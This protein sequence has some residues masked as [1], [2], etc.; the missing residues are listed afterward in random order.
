MTREPGNSTGQPPLEGAGESEGS[1]PGNSIGQPPLEGEGEGEEGDGGGKVGEQIDDDG[2]GVRTSSVA[3]CLSISCQTRTHT[4][5]TRTSTPS[6]LPSVVHGQHP[7]LP[8]SARP[9]N[10]TSLGTLGP[11][12]YRCPAQYAA[13]GTTCNRSICCELPAML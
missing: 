3:G 10:S 13:F 1:E 11:R 12:K 7:T 5:I 9:S 4:H 8:L 2:I 6:F